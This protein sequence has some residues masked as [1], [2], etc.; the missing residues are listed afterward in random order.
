MNN[1]PATKPKHL[2]THEPTVIHDAERDETLLLRWFRRTLEKGPIVWVIAAGVI[3]ACCL[4]WIILGVGSN[5][6]SVSDEAWIDYVLARSAEDQI[7][8][9]ERL[10]EVKAGP[11]TGWSLLRAAESQFQEAI[12]DLPGNRDVAMPL[13]SKARDLFDQAADRAGE[14]QTLR[15]LAEM[16]A[17]RVK[18]TRGELGEASQ[19]YKKIAETWPDSIEGKRARELVA[20]LAKPEVIA[21]YQEF[22]RFKPTGL[23]AGTAG[24]PGSSLFL[25][26]GGTSDLNLPGLPAN[27]PPLDGPVV[28]APGLTPPGTVPSPPAEGAAT[29][30]AAPGP[31]PD[32]SKA[33]ELPPDPFATVPAPKP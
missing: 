12:N 4:V 31:G 11:A 5:T 25:P 7:K 30:P 24:T 27:H 17:A 15:R 29:P 2:Q 21:F 26:P 33:A 18:E 19:I 6:R 20:Q 16:G 32:T 3:A 14:D 22:S 28:P 23:G 1:E 13:L 10:V 8:L 9:A